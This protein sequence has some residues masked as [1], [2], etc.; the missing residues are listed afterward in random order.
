MS[1]IYKYQVHEDIF[2]LSILK[3]EMFSL[4]SA[5]EVLELRKK[6][7]NNKPH[8]FVSDTTLELDDST[9]VSMEVA[10]FMNDK[11]VALLTKGVGVIAASSFK[12]FAVNAALMLKRVDTPVKLF[13]NK[14]D[15][16]YWIQKLKS[17]Q[18][19]KIS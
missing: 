9:G 17:K 8:F 14:K 16:F 18:F 19:E 15:A 6:L 10:D 1:E 3:T 2:I 7:F 5:K 13:N 11:E 12:R 4:E